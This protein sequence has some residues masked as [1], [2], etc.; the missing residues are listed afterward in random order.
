MVKTYLQI[1]LNFVLHKRLIK[2]SKKKVLHSALMS[3]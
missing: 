3:P 2:I 1:E